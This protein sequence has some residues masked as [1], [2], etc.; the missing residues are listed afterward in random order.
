MCKPPDGH[1]PKPVKENRVLPFPPKSSPCLSQPFPPPINPKSSLFNLS[2]FCGPPPVLSMDGDIFSSLAR[3]VYHLS[4]G[5]PSTR[6]RGDPGK[7][8]QIFSLSLPS[9]PEKWIWH[10][11]SSAASRRGSRAFT[12]EPGSILLDGVRV[13]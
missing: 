11:V 3:G 12:R 10:I 6:P 5:S 8:S 9:N 1:F 2:S 13:A 4:Q 7:P